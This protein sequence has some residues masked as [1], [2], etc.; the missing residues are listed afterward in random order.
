MAVFDYQRVFIHFFRLD[1]DF[2]WPDSPWMNGIQHWISEK[3]RCVLVKSCLNPMEFPGSSSSCGF[4]WNVIFAANADNFSWGWWWTNGF[5]PIFSKPNLTCVHDSN[6][7]NDIG[8][9]IPI[10]WNRGYLGT[11]FFR[12]KNVRSDFFSLSKTISGT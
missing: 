9:V 6:L 7:W 12:Q 3:S 10:H 5:S 4:V 1:A 8:I 2:C 11:L